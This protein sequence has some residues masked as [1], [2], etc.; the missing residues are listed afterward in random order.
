MTPSFA[1]SRICPR[2]RS[3][4]RPQGLGNLLSG[5]WMEDALAFTEGYDEKV[6]K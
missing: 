6:G 1:P 3:C 5:G 2:Q 4:E